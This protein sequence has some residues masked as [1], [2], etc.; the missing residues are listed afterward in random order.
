MA[1]VLGMASP[2][3]RAPLVAE[4]LRIARELHD[5]VT[6]DVS[7]ML[8]LAQAARSTMDADPERAR[9]AIAAMEQAGREAVGELRRLLRILEP[10]GAAS[11]APA[12]APQP[13]LQR[14]SALLARA[15]DAGLEVELRTEGESG[16]LSPGLDL[17]AFRIVEE[18]LAD[19]LGQDDPGY[20]RV[21]LRWSPAQL[22]VE[23]ASSAGGAR[24][25]AALRERAAICGGVLRAGPSGRGYVVRARLPRNGAALTPP[26]PAA[27]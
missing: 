9:A 17:N 10:D 27:A 12:V 5:I 1:T 4:R 24:N 6:H 25:L 22:E 13:S 16:P 11:A 8:I 20:A 19:V 7:E 18:A 14:L 21:T 15:R 3:Q 2:D 23:I 26:A